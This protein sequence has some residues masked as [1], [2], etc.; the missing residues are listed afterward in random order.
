MAIYKLNSKKKG[1]KNVKKIVGFTLIG[2]SSVA[3]LFLTGIWSPIFNFLLGTF[4]VFAYALFLI[5][6]IVGLALVNN[7]RYVMSMRYL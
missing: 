3:Y 7:R 2:V 5:L 1:G 6:F 4:G